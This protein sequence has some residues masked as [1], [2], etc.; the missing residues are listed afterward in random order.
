MKR[1]PK[2]SGFTLVELLVVITIIA[3][4]IAL[5]LPAVQMAREAAR[6]LQC[7][8]NLKQLA[9]A[10]LDHEHAN[11]FLPSGG[12][13]VSWVG[14]PNR[15]FGRKQP[16]GWAYSITP[17]M[18]LEA[19]HNLGLGAA[20]Q[21]AGSASIVQCMATPVSALICPSRRAPIPYPVVSIT[22][23]YYITGKIAS[24]TLVGKTD[25]G[26]N[27]GT[28]VQG[29][30]MPGGPD[31]LSAGDS[32]PNSSASGDCWNNQY[33]A[34]DTGVIYCHSQTSMADISDGSS[35]TYLIGEKYVNS[36]V[37]YDGT[38]PYDDS[39]W[40]AGADWDILRWSGIT[41]APASTAYAPQQDAPGVD[42][43]M[44]F[45]SAHAGTFNMAMCDGSVQGV[46]YNVD[47][48]THWRLGNRSD[49]EPV[50]AK[51]LSSSQ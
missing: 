6:R 5:L 25:Y 13:G 49:G 20:T 51:N 36:D 24:P 2:T 28:T 27:A 1:L 41:T 9:L 40:E 29:E 32:W 46:S 38:G 7:G 4:L 50:D 23:V 16:G 44:T 42:A 45:G 47:V 3:I 12:W 30:A 8:N 22:N 31:S 21:A 10:S 35:N 15:G 17:Y 26:A 39:S 14:D 34:M 37:Y 43:G 33:H 18:E 48:L 11:H 19:L